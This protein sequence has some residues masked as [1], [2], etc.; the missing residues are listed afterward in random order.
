M[1]KSWNVIS[2]HVLFTGWIF[3][4]CS[5]WSVCIEPWCRPQTVLGCSQHEPMNWGTN[6]APWK[7]DVFWSS[8]QINGNLID[9][10][11]RIPV[12][13]NNGCVCWVGFA[14]LF[15]IS[16][17]RSDFLTRFW[18]YL[19]FCRSSVYGVVICAWP[20]EMPQVYF[21]QHVC[22]RQLV[23]SGSR[24]TLRVGLQTETRFR[25]AKYQVPVKKKKGGV[26]ALLIGS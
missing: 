3:H 16:K 5:V 23:S 1:I 4:M 9:R 13:L 14:F 19:H 6:W 2:P 18:F 12:W 10:Q 24:H 20:G 26:S 22:S 11:V 25:I 7:C 17:K 15:N 8:G 21:F